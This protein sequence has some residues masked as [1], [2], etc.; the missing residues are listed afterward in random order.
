MAARPRAPQ[1]QAALASG[2]ALRWQ[3]ARL[4]FFRR[5]NRAKRVRSRRLRARCSLVGQ[6]P[7][8]LPRLTAHSPRL[9]PGSAAG[10]LFFANRSSIWNVPISDCIIAA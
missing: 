3:T 7:A 10:Q 4:L 9:S 2:P 1:K 8:D 6:F 5:E